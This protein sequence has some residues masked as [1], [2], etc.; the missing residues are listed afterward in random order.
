MLHTGNFIL[1]VASESN[2][3]Y[4][5][6]GLSRIFRFQKQI[7]SN[8]KFY[9]HKTSIAKGATWSVNQILFVNIM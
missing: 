3:S 5:Y 7:A 8:R 4:V 9:F 1:K 2:F 6:S